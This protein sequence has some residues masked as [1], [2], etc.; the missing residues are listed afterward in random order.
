MAQLAAGRAALQRAV[1]SAALSGAASYSANSAAFNALAISVAAT[2]FCNAASTFPMGATVVARANGQTCTSGAGPMVT[3]TTDSYIAGTPGIS[4]AAGVSCTGLYLPPAP[5]KCGF[6]VT[7]SASVT[8]NAFLPT[9]FGAALTISASGMA[10]NPFI[11]FATIFSIPGGVLAGAKYANSIWAYPLLLDAS[12]GVDYATNA[13]ALPDSSSC[14]GGPDQTVCGQ[15]IMLASTMYK[16]KGVGY[17][18][19]G[20]TIIYDDGIVRNPPS[21]TQVTATTPLGIAFRTIAGGNYV[22]YSSPGVYGYRIQ[23]LGANPPKY[24]YAPTGCIYPYSNLVYHTV[25]QVWQTV[26][27][28]AN[29]VTTTSYIPL[30]PWPLVTHWFYSSYLLQNRPPSQGEITAQFA[31]NEVIPSVVLDPAQT[32]GNISGWPTYTANPSPAVAS[33]CPGTTTASGVTTSNDMYQTTTFPTTGNTNCSLYITRSATSGAIPPNGSYAGSC[34]DPAN[35][36]GQQYAAMSCQSYGNAFYTFYW[37]DMGGAIS[38]NA[39]Y[40]DGIVQLSCSS[41]SHVILIQ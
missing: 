23:S 14:T 34:F 33:T 7:V 10:A 21:P 18:P 4:G 2:A 6:I 39:N 31:N 5:Y 20:Q 26:T 13:G 38:D 19:P 8:I 41:A 30:L 9:L 22:Q 12:G 17:T 1:D 35:T 28:T 36:P 11:D 40:G 15:Y 3:A 29:G 25:G 32:G 24:A 27:A 37:N 16:N